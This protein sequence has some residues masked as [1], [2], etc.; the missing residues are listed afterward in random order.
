[1]DDD[2]DTE[3]QGAQDGAD[4]L[5]ALQKK[6]AE[7]EKDNAKYRE[8]RRKASEQAFLS[9][10]GEE[11]AAEVADLPEDKREAWADKLL[12]LKSS[13]PTGSDEPAPVEVPKVETKPGLAAVVKDPAPG[14]AEGQTLTP[15]EFKRY[16]DAEGL[17][18]AAQKYGH[19]VRFPDLDNPL[20]TGQ[21]ANVQGTYRP[22]S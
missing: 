4:Q 13:A 18:A 17:N 22:P 6:I 3:A 12:A 15:E 20:A 10:Y 11:I 9:K 1:M 5:A 19:L 2:F 14:A 21:A 8:E 7:L 16:V